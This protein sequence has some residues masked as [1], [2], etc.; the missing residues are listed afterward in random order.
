MRF[1]FDENFSPYLIRGLREFQLGRRSEN[2]EVMS[3]K[4]EFGQGTKDEDWIP[5]VA[6][7]HGVAVTF[8]LNINRIRAQRHLWTSHKLGMVFFRPPKK[9][10]WNYWEKVQITVKMWQ[11][12]KTICSTHSAPFAFI[13]QTPGPK[14]SP[15]VIE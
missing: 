6:Q 7:A 3:I 1:Y 15:I 5:K 2:F 11:E 14:F 8:D 9:K 4:E 12:M 10:S 13:L